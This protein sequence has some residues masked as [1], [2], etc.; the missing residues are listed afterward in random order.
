MKSYEAEQTNWWDPETL[1]GSERPGR[2]HHNGGVFRAG[3]FPM[4]ASIIGG[5]ALLGYGL[6]RRDRRGLASAVAGSA[7]LFQGSRQAKD[8]GIAEALNP[9]MDLEYSVTIMRPADELYRF[10]E[11]PENFPRFMYRVKRVI[12]LGNHRQRWIFAG[13]RKREIE[14]RVEVISNI[15]NRLISWQTEPG[16]P[17]EEW[18][19]V[20]FTPALRDGETEVTMDISYRMPAGY[21]GK[22]IAALAG[23]DPAQLARESL[24]RFKQLM[25]AGEIATTQGQPSGRRGIADK[26]MQ[27][28]LGEHAQLPAAATRRRVG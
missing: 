4:W 23:L 16:Q 14:L 2:G 7:L 26:G 10:W 5:G 9:E 6:M 3:E 22:G 20:E 17:Y 12:D 27:M 25:E 1:P 24:R 11:N 28:L 8:S 21:L 15:P 18:G 13:P 19:S